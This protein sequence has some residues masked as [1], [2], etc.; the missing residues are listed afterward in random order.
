MIINGADLLKLA[1][2]VG[3][4]DEKR[5]TEFGLS[6]G[7]TECGYDIC[8]AQD[9]TLFLGRRFVL[10][11]SEERFDMPYGVMGKVYNKS[12]L[13]RMGLDASR[14]TNI[15]PG[16]SG[17]LTLELHYAKV[18]P[19]RLKAGQ[20]IAQ[21]IFEELKNRAA[22]SGKYQD[23]PNRPV[24]AILTKPKLTGSR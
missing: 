10:A 7:L 2:I 13:A 4:I 3:M 19:L 18:W 5:E 14:T 15:E 8:L 20:P 11:H 6:Y 17:H 16:W 23:Q 21:I 9:V 22:Y 24:G 12:T 1:P